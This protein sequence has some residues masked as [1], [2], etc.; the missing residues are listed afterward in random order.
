[1]KSVSFAHTTPALLAGRKTV[2]R[3]EWKERYAL[4]F[5]EGELL[6]ALDKDRRA[7]GKPVAVIRLTQAPV[8]SNEYPA[9]DY[10]AEGFAWMEDR[11]LTV[12]GVSP[13]ALWRRWRKERPFFWVVRFEVLG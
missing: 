8:W 5:K 12:M 7:G 9:E 6:T 10:E 1:M 2:T 3:R 13:L 11:G 4:S